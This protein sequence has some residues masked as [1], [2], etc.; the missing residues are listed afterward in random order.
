MLIPIAANA[1]N[2]GPNLATKNTPA[3]TIVAAWIRA[4]T[5]VGPVIASSS[6][7]LSGNCADFPTAPPKSNTA[8]GINRCCADIAVAHS[9]C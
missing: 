6:H 4:E 2:N 7:S 1:K 3:L 9:V 8:A 5:A